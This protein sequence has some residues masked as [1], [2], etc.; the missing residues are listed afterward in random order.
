MTINGKVSSSASYSIITEGFIEFS[1]SGE[2]LNPDSFTIH[3]GEVTDVELLVDRT[4]ITIYEEFY[5]QVLVEDY[6]GLERFGELTVSLVYPEGFVATASEFVYE[7]NGLNLFSGYGTASGKYIFSAIV[8]GNGVRF[9]SKSSIV[10]IEPANIHL[11]VYPMVIFMQP[12][13]IDLPFVVYTFILDNSGTVLEYA[14]GL[15]VYLEI[16]CTEATDCI[17]PL[18][19]DYLVTEN[20]RSN[21]T[22][23]RLVAWDT[24]QI[25]ATGDDLYSASVIIGELG[26]TEV[27]VSVGLYE[28]DI[29]IFQEFE[30]EVKLSAVNGEPYPKATF[31]NLMKNGMVFERG[32]YKGE[33][34]VIFEVYSNVPGIYE[35]GVSLGLCENSECIL[36][37]LTVEIGNANIILET[38]FY[39]ITI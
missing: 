28:S 37:Y 21:T 20:G 35:F 2:D 17:D 1:A 19:E 23:H 22:E 3:N 15:L 18:L 4:N 25:L 8:S 27:N 11:E 5:I 31:V 13:D 26:N 9:T 12:N 6:F 39:V 16:N 29:T 32:Y 34:S 14:E 38:D 7:E 24:Y 10:Q 33:G 36:G 30:I